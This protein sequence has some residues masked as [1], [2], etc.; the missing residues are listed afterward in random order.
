MYPLSGSGKGDGIAVNNKTG[1]ETF[2]KKFEVQAGLEFGIKKFTVGNC[3]H[4]HI[5]RT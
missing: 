5:I 2:M 1:E 3:A 4:R